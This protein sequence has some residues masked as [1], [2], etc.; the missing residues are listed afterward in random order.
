MSSRDPR[1]LGYG[2]NDLVGRAGLEQVYERWLR[3][4][5]GEQKFIVNADG[6][7]SVRSGSVRREAGHDLQ[8]AL[9]LEMQRTP[10]RSCGRGWSGHAGSTDSDGRGP[11]GLG[12]G[13]A[14][15][16]DAG[17]R[18]GRG[19]GVDPVVRPRVVR[20]GV[21]EGT[22]PVPVRIDALAPSAE[23]GD[24]GTVLP[25]VDVQADERSRGGQG[26]LRDAVR[27]L[28]VHDQVRPPRR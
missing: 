3:G 21:H 5:E 24:A 23:P 9:D 8:L 12:S 4:K 14:V 2:N 15:M 27:L 20:G 18:R 28:P 7:R 26:G 10:S 6:E 11:R 17:E 1:F 13:V 22:A 19:D 25:G 16:L